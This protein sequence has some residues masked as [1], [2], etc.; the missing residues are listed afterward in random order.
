MIIIQGKYTFAK[1]FTDEIEKNAY[2]QIVNLCNSV[3][4]E[5]SK[6]RIMPDVHAGVGCTI[7][8]TM[9]LT[10]KVVPN[11]VGVD[12]GCGMEVLKLRGR[13]PN[14][15]QLDRAIHRLIPSGFNI[16]RFEHENSKKLDYESINCYKHI[17]LDRAK[18]SIGTLGGGNHFVELNRGKEGD[19]YLV[20]HS[21]SRNPGN[22]TA[23][24][25]Q[26]LAVKEGKKR[27]SGEDASLAYLEGKN[28][29]AYLEDMKFMQNYAHV[30]R[31]TM[32]EIIVDALDL[33]VEESFSTIHN[34]IDT[35]DMILRKG[36]ISAKEKEI[37]LIPINMRDGSLICEGK[38]NSDWNYSAPHG[39]GRIMSRR[40]AKSQ[41]TLDVF[42]KTMEGIYTTTADRTTIDECALAYKPMEEILKNTRDTITVLDTIRPLY[43]FKGSG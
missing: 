2:Q 17:N 32:A 30:N 22:Q 23:M 12:I 33:D 11:L 43:N 8:T 24:Y 13:K 42:K 3:A 36:A 28:M 25:Y 27:K 35:R 31:R 14:L 38:G 15:E 40:Q 9:T 29:H 26:R 41:I 6:V 5:N 10:D 20:I 1:V 18:K 7:G 16:R 34:Y 19:I 39:A 4:A 37:V 21:G